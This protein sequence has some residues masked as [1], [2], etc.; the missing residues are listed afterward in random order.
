M[1]LLVGYSVSYSY[2][3][4]CVDKLLF[5]DYRK[6]VLLNLSP[7]CLRHTLSVYTSLE[8]QL[9]PVYVTFLSFVFPYVI[10]A[11]CS[12]RSSSRILSLMYLNQVGKVGF[13]FNVLLTVHRG[14]FK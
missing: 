11:I 5:T 14:I 12:S 1:F 2:V 6:V 9:M 8:R 3:G 4:L 13:K 10:R 7:I